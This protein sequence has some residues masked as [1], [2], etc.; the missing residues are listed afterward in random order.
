MPRPRLL[1]S[2]PALLAVLALAACGSSGSKRR[3]RHPRQADLRQR[4]A[5]SAP[6][7]W[8]CALTVQTH[9]PG[10]RWPGRSSCASAGRSP[11]PRPRQTPR[12]SPSRSRGSLA[13]HSF[14]AGATSTGKSGYLAPRAGVLP[15]ARRPVRRLPEVVLLRPGPR[16]AE[17]ERGREDPVAQRPDERR[18]RRRRRARG[19]RRSRPPSTW[20]SSLATLDDAARRPRGCSAKQRQGIVDAVKNP[21]FDFYTGASDHILRRVTITFRS[22]PRLG[23]AAARR[24]EGRRR[25]PRLLDRRAEP[26]PDH[27]RRRP[28]SAQRRSWPRACAILAQKLQ[29]LGSL[30]NGATGAT[31]SSGSGGTTARRGADPAVPGM[32]DQGGRG[33]RRRS[34]GASP[35]L[36]AQPTKSGPVSR[37][38]WPYWLTPF[39]PIAIV[40]DVRRGDRPLRSF[41]A[42]ALGVVPTAALMSRATEELADRPGPGIGGLLNVTFGNAPELIIALFALER[43]PARG[44][45]GLAHR[46]DPRQHPARA[47]RRDGRRRARPR[48]PVLRPHRRDGPVLDAPARRRR[49]GH[50]RDLRARR[51]QGLPTPGAER[52]NYGG[53]VEALSY[54]V[55]G[56]LHRLLRAQSGLLAEDAPLAVQPA[57]GARARATTPWPVRQVGGHARARRRRRGR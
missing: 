8:R 14:T 1:A 9:G 3:R 50:A 53:N 4:R 26:A 10:R 41:F 39:I 33:R 54:A 42:S 37:V 18:D 22:R 7:S 46:L 29:A 23:P 28:T 13:G 16:A 47:R 24:P 36:Q 34:R 5:R 15:A 30:P 6:A 25:H 51:G 27:R 20:P 2:L 43:G 11:S 38:P 48:A 31:G 44:G 57:R 45:Q 40:L 19:R 52:V 49:A 12:S 21:R 35:S 55:A 56:V 32:P 17:D